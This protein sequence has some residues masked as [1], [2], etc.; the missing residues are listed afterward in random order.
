MSELDQALLEL[1]GADWQ[2]RVVEA[3]MFAHA[4]HPECR[5]WT[6]G[7]GAMAKA[8]CGHCRW[9]IAARMEPMRASGAFAMIALGILGAAI[10][11]ALASPLANALVTELEEAR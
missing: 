1:A 5:G 8:W 11:I 2:W 6:M 9:E 7:V 3:A 10:E 4:T